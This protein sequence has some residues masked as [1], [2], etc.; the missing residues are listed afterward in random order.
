VPALIIAGLLVFGAFVLWQARNRREPLVPLRLFRDR[1]FSLSNVGISAMGFAITAMAFPLMLYAQLVRGLSPTGSALLLVP[2]AVMSIVLAPYVGR[3]TDRVH[4]RSLTAVGF[5]A[6]V[7]SLVWL[8]RVMTP[9]SHTWEILLPM[10]LLGIGNACVWAPLS[11]TATRN[12]PL[13]LA[14]AGAGVY[15]ATRQVGAVLGSAAIA[16][17]MDSRLA[18]HGL[19]F[20]PT[21][22]TAGAAMPA[23][24]LNGFSNAMAD[25]ML[26]PALVLL[27]G[28][29]AVLFFEPSQRPVVPAPA[30][31]PV[32]VS[33]G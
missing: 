28:L 18:A 11:A 22:A 17:L 23:A 24:A 1:N 4:P 2:M 19:A 26:L 9:T 25:A 13:Q 20:K 30:P 5:T 15:N 33:A 6:I 32:E 29:L 21:E 3:L 14:G 31:A 12:L 27:L 10:V 8:S 16:V 7:A